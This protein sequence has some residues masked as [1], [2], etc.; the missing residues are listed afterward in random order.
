MSTQ[1]GSSSSSVAPTA[2]AP[3]ASLDSLFSPQNTTFPEATKAHVRESIADLELSDV[4]LD[5]E[6][7]ED[8]S[9]DHGSS[10]ERLELAKL[11]VL[12]LDLEALSSSAPS[13]HKKSAS[14]T[15][16]HSGKHIS[17]LVNRDE[18]VQSNRGSV[19]GQ[20]KLQEKFARLQK[21]RVDGD[22]DDVPVTPGL[23]PGID[24]G[25]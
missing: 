7:L 12:D 24:W 11:P 1:L 22:D 15:T 4:S 6:S 14:L 20:H 13:S 9:A 8:L 18:Q 25:E 2:S 10:D 19:D 23:V 5:D 21:G 3:P 17:L 16:L